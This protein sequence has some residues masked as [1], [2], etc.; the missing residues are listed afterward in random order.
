MKVLDATR[1]MA[2]SSKASAGKAE[3]NEDRST[4]GAVPLGSVDA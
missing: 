1:V 2:G 3:A 4:S